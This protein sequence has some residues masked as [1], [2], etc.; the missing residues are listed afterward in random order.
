MW[1]LKMRP[2]ESPKHQQY[3]QHRHCEVTQKQ[4]PFLWE[5]L[6]KVFAFSFFVF[7]VHC[8]DQFS[9]YSVKNSFD[10][11]SSPSV[12]NIFDPFSGPLK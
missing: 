7:I 5:I 2:Q 12:K 9:S 4:S 6:Q 8:F 10:Q 3:S 11:L 1:I